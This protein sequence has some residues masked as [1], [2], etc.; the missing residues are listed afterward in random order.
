MEGAAPEAEAEAALRSFK[1]ELAAARDSE[2][3]TQRRKPAPD[4][5]VAEQ[6][7]Q[8]LDLIE[9]PPDDDSDEAEGEALA[10]PGTPD[11]PRRGGATKWISSAWRKR[12][13]IRT[14]TKSISASC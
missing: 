13:R 6:I 2:M 4:M 8:A 3:A 9:R 7:Q 1:A 12:P 10:L 11:R 5:G 14:L